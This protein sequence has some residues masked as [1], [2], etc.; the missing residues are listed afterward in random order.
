MLPSFDKLSRML[1]QEKRLGYKNKAIL[2]GL[3][4]L[5]PNW[6]SEARQEAANDEERTLIAE[7]VQDL[8]RYPEVPEVDRPHFIHKLL[9][10]L[11]K[12]GTAATNNSERLEPAR[13]KQDPVAVS[14]TPLNLPPRWVELPSPEPKPLPSMPVTEESPEPALPPSQV[15]KTDFPKK[16][17]ITLKPVAAPSPPSP[18]SR[19]SREAQPDL[20]NAGLDSLVTKLPGIK[21]AMAKKL[22]NLGVRTIGDF[23]NLYPRRYDDYRSLKPINQLQYG[24]EVTII[25]QVWETRQR[26]SRGRRPIVTSTLSDGTA[27]MEV[28]WFN[29][30]WLAQKLRPGM[31]IVLSGRVEEYLGR[32]TF[33]SPDWEEL[34]KNLI[35]TGRMVPVYPLTEGI[36]IK[37]L[38]NQIK[39]TV[40]YW[41]RRL[42]DYLP[43]EARQRLGFLSLDEAIRQIHF[44]DDWNKLEAA[45][46]RLA[47]DELLL[48]QLGV[49]RQRRAWQA[50][51]GQPVQISSE[52]IERLLQALPFE[53]TAAQRKALD[54]IIN[55]LRRD[56]PMSRLLQ[57]DVGS[58]K[59]VVALAAMVLTVLDGGQSAIL[60]PTEILAEQHFQSMS[61]LLIPLGE[62]LGRP[63]RI[64]LLIGSTSAAKRKELLENLV[65]GQIDIL[66]GTH[67]IIQSNVEL[68]NLRLAVIDEQHRFGVEQRSA[69]REKGFNPHMLVMTATPIPRTLTLTIY[70]DLDTSVLDE[71]PPG[72]QEIKT[73][74][75]VSTE[76]DK[77]YKHLRR[78]ISR[79]RQAYVVCPL[80][81]ESEK[82]DLPSAEE[83][84]VILDGTAEV[85]AGEGRGRRFLTEFRRGDVFGEMGFVRRSERTAD[86][87]ATSDVEVLA[88]DK[89]FLERVQRRY[90]RIASKVF[91]NL[92]RILSNSLERTTRQ[93]VAA[94]ARA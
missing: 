54:E 50:Q 90:P 9:V 77:A 2:G 51:Q 48:I 1:T 27:T 29:Q 15:K 75:I 88:V 26:D 31:Q 66:V 72:R 94:A 62:A 30:P 37:W 24:E 59:T 60:A 4:K 17:P 13:E 8:G 46:R 43:D 40:D 85:W 7:I 82:V 86:V 55:D 25:A 44:P 80:V 89:R 45:R 53:L 11:H 93:V 35:H 6:G 14:P 28:T 83:M 3:E 79:G 63:F 41:T 57:G 84:Y 22:A 69:L 5:V 34:D 92:T 21:E 52:A 36:T 78:E 70:G 87:V 20:S 47:F 71:L 33:Q 42:P 56:T 73:R 32:L 58:G 67:A 68:K 38:R 74:W 19:P 61:K 18:A 12:A 23:L 39:A 16:S 64:Q 10:K 49:L 91:L 65:N 81:D 76:R